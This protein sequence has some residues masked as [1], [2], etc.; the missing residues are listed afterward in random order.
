MSNLTVSDLS[1]LDRIRLKSSK[2]LTTVRNYYFG[3]EKLKPENKKFKEKS[4]LADIYKICLM[5][6][7]FQKYQFTTRESFISYIDKFQKEKNRLKKLIKKL[8]VEDYDSQHV[9]P[10]D[11]PDN[12]PDDAFFAFFY[13]LGTQF[14]IYS[15]YLDL[16][17]WFDLLNSVKDRIFKEYE[18]EVP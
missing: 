4:T 10:Y 3:Q 7:N 16:E 6:G 5:F 8:L 9:Y 17:Y 1:Y 18:K 14:E 15:L 13:Y 2:L 12:L 11:L